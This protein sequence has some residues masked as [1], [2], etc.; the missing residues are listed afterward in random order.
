MIIPFKI[1]LE[2]TS[3]TLNVVTFQLLILVKMIMRSLLSKLCLLN[4]IDQLYHQAIVYT[5]NF[6]CVK[7]FLVIMQL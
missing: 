1:F 5:R 4:L 2:H 3:Q 6:I 7:Y